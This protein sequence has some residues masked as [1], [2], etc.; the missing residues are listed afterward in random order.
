MSIVEKSRNRL[1]SLYN[2]SHGL[3][4]GDPHGQIKSA[5]HAQ[6]CSAWLTATQNMVYLLVRNP[7][8]P[9]RKK[10]DRI[11]EGA[12]GYVINEAVGE[13]AEVL[14]NLARDAD[15]GLIDS[16]VNAAQAE[17]FDDFLDHAEHYLGAN[18]KQPAGVIAGVVF[19]DTIR[20]LCRKHSIVE[21]GERIDSLITA[22]DKSGQVTAVQAKRARAAASLRT[23]ATHAQWEEFELSDVRATIAFTRE[24]IEAKLDG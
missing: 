23:S 20:R 8:S 1:M 3:R 4:Q 9:Y 15:E 18:R 24:I 16:I 14:L 22:L 5:Q 11:A 19:E 17:V 7:A 6:Q 13:A 12:H 21:A 2:E 10:I